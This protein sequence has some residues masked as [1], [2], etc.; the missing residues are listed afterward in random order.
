MV[1]TQNIDTVALD[2]W[3]KNSGYRMNHFSDTLGITRQSFSNKCK[4]KTQFKL[5]EV[6]VIAHMLGMTDQ[7]KDSIFF[8]KNVKL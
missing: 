4:G 1:K 6:Y 3:L 5:S 7:E 8:P 2:G